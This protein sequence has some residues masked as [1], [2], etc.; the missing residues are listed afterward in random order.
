LN[1]QGYLFVVLKK[2]HIMKRSNLKNQLL[3]FVLSFISLSAQ[4]ENEPISDDNA[5]TQ[6]A[7]EI[8]TANEIISDDNH[9]MEFVRE[10]EKAMAVITKAICLMYEQKTKGCCCKQGPR[11]PQGVQGATGATGVNGENGATGATGV[12]GATGAAG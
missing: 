2:E 1:Y 10:I 4:Q 5:T 9:T 7:E 6:S 3:F 8:N 12:T 11:G